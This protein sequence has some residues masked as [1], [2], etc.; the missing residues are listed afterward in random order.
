[1]WN[2]IVAWFKSKGGFAHVLAVVFVFLMAAYAAV[3]EF[4][5]LVLQVHA[6]LPGWVQEL[7]TTGLALWAWYKTTS[8]S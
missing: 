6:L 1:M 3:P 8:N 7:V 2:S 5:V 4:H